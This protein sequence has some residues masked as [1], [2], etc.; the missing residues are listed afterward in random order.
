MGRIVS[1]RGTLIGLTYFVSLI[2]LVS[3]C[4]LFLIPKWSGIWSSLFSDELLY[5]V[6]L[7]L[8]TGLI[9]TVL[10]LL[11]SVPIAY[12]FSRYSFP[13][14]RLAKTVL[15]LPIAFPE[16]VLGLC[17]LLFLGGPCT[18]RVLDALNMDF[19]FT[20]KG[21]VVAQFFTALPYAVRVT[22]T[23][24]DGIDI[25][26]EFVSRSL[27]YSQM[28]TAI[29]VTLPLAKE[30]L[31]AATAISFARCIGAFGSVLVLA[32]G[33]RMD[34]ETLPIALYLNLSYGN[35]DMAVTAGLMLVVVAFIGILIVETMESRSSTVF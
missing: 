7:S 33:T 2:L 3:I 28:K 19:V 31:K 23:V 35:M 32:G 17:L 16:L 13:G 29:F 24:F 1:M 30:G 20:K 27:G 11:M 18:R 15:Y 26:L 34:T 5:S 22:K 14:Q 9:S 21:I 25:Q 8:I 10:V 4:S 6:S 12:S